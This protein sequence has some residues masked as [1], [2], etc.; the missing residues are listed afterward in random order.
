MSTLSILMLGQPPAPLP[1]NGNI[2]RQA[3]VVGAGG[4]GVGVGVGAGV[5]VT[6]VG[7]DTGAK[8][9]V[10]GDGVIG[11]G[12]VGVAVVVHGGVVHGCVVGNIITVG[13]GVGACVGTGTGTGLGIIIGGGGGGKGVPDP[14]LYS[15]LLSVITLL[16]E[17]AVDAKLAVLR[18]K[19]VSCFCCIN[20]AD[21]KT[22][23]AV[24]VESLSSLF[25]LSVTL[26]YLCLPSLFPSG[27]KLPHS[28]PV[29]D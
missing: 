10:V 24:V 29:N 19:I 15:I 16:S 20:P 12:K 7:V 22:A 17:N 28:L 6:I 9:V 27:I 5:V 21:S 8:V 13:G 3:A 1:L 4:I 2:G 26:K 23:L 14:I 11:G 18:A 25:G